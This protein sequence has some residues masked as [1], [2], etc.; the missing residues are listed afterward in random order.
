[1]ADGVILAGQK[2]LAFLS[3]DGELRWEARVPGEANADADVH[4]ACG[5]ES[6]TALRDGMTTL[7]SFDVLGTRGAIGL[8]EIESATLIS[9]TNAG[10]LVSGVDANGITT[11][12]EAAVDSGSMRTVLELPPA[13]IRGNVITAGG[14][15]YF[16]VADTRQ[17]EVR[18]YD[19]SGKL[20]SR[21]TWAGGTQLS[22]PDRIK[23]DQHGNVWVRML[24]DPHRWSV[25]TDTR[26]WM[27]LS[28]MPG[29][30]SLESTRLGE[31]GVIDDATGTRVLFLRLL[32]P[33][34][35]GVLPF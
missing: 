35:A 33:S 16:L 14:A 26:I 18:A 4:V 17:P 15:G 32:L 27:S 12:F 1:M 24:E 6:V 30:R 9:R 34:R 11:I 19:L 31:L 25:L 5:A 23:L 22:G 8:P 28:L 7:H 13:R 29:F 20:L 10:V 21:V 3:L 2:G